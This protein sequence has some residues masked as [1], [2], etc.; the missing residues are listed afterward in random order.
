MRLSSYLPFALALSG[1]SF[2]S[3]H[4]VNTSTPVATDFIQ[5]NIIPFE[6]TIPQP[7]ICP[8]SNMHSANAQPH[9]RQ[10]NPRILHILEGSLIAALIISAQKACAYNKSIRTPN[11]KFKP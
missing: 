2:R 3:I 6:K 11:V 5:K 9:C 7:L 4:S 1:C 8:S 10:G